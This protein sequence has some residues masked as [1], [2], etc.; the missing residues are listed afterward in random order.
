MLVVAA[1]AIR[2][3]R[4]AQVSRSHRMRPCHAAVAVVVADAEAAVSSLG[5]HPSPAG[6][7]DLEVSPAVVAAAAVAAVSTLHCLSHPSVALVAL[8]AL[9]LPVWRSSFTDRGHCV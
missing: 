3:R 5:T 7:E 1:E 6:P 9:A 2:E 8:V 4:A